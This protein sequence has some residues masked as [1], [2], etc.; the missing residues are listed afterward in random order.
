[1]SPDETRATRAAQLELADFAPQGEAFRAEVVAGLCRSPKEISCKFLYDETGSH[2]FEAICGLEEYYPTRTE[3]A[4]L[5]RRVGEMAESLGPRC[6]LIEYGSGSGKKTEVLLAALH[7]PVGYVPIEI[8]R[9]HLMAA[10]A[11]LKER[12]PKL[13]VLPICADYTADY[14]VPEPAAAA[15]RRVVFFP[16]STIGNFERGDAVVFLRH[17]AETC[18]T[19]GGLLIGVDLVKD[20]RILERAYDDALGVTAAFNLNLLV[21]LNRELGADFDVGA[22]RHRAWYD[23]AAGRVEMHLESARAQTVRIGGVEISFAAGETVCTEHSHKY[24]LEGFRELAREAGFEVERVWTDDE[25][26]FSV[27]YLIA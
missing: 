25:R 23:E 18:G 15:R 27:Q 17:V 22:F 10:A 8:S 4:I 13:E 7:E 21:R 11:R 2:L 19:G 14:E 6:L 24:T 26:L 12:F 5:D 1:M 9:D 3:L 20:R 16:G